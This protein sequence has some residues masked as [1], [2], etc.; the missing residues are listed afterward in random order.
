M[1][2]LNN[3][4]EA[5]EDRAATVQGVRTALAIA[6]QP[7]FRALS[8]RPHH[9]PASDSEADILDFLRRTSHTV[10]HPVGT[11]AMGTVVD[12]QLRVRGLEDLRVIDASVIPEIPNA[13]TNAATIMIAEKG[14]DLVAGRSRIQADPG[15]TASA[16]AAPPVAR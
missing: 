12:D 13:N 5:P 7:E 10:W 4:L 1:R 15:V 3:Y 2:I 11:C 14:A 16:G 8:Q 9:V 6:D